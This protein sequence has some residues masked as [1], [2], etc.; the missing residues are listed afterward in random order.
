MEQTVEDLERIPMSRGQFDELPDEVR[1]EYVDGVA[2]VSPT[3]R[4]GHNA[5]GVNVALALRTAYPDAFVT[6]ERGLELP[7]GRLR[8][9]DMALQRDGDDDL[10]S[11]TMPLLVVEILSPSTRDEGL[12]RKTDDYRLAGIDQYWIIDRTSRMLTVLVN[13]GERWDIALALSKEHPT[14]T[15][16]LADLGPIELDLTA[17]LV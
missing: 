15:I 12:F 3:A 1:A 5:T 16:E 7:D 8:I 2:I 6:Y 11:T 13:A 9:P 4:G 17:L 10:W 14:G